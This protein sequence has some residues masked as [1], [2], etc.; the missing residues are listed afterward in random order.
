MHNFN[1]NFSLLHTS[2]NMYN[3]NFGEEDVIPRVGDI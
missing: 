2:P 1:A 3:Y